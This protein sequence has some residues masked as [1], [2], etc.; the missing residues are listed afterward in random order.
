MSDESEP[1]SGLQ[2]LKEAV[3]QT[4]ASGRDLQSHVSELVFSALSTATAQIDPAHL[5]RVT[6]AALEGVG[7]GVQ[8]G[9]AGS[10]EVIRKSVAGVEDALL[11]TAGVSHLAIEEAAGHVEE[12]SKT[13]LRRA[14]DELA[15]LQELFLNV[16][17]DVAKAG[18]KTAA[19]AFTDIQRHIRDSGGALGTMLA[20]AG[21]QAD[22]AP[23]GREALGFVDAH[24][25]DVILSDIDMPGINGVQ[26]LREIRAR[27]LDVP[28]LLIT[29]HPRV[30][31]AVEALEH[32]AL[33]LHRHHP[34]RDDQ[35]RIGHKRK[36]PGSAG[37][38]S[39]IKGRG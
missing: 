37:P 34:A 20:D 16:L 25:Y 13:D 26:L 31:T 35:Q 1:D 23:G 8:T 15:S 12:F 10:A 6:R 5:Q 4:V 21:W 9:G 24:R 33:R 28:V 17:G 38:W 3:R 29:G 39:T 11:K 2:Q 32:G 22:T 7:A 36:G 18:S 14:V 19:T 27:D 30:D